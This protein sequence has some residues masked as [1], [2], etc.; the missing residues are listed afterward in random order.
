MAALQSHSGAGTIMALAVVSATV[1]A[2]TFGQIAAQQFYRQEQLQVVA[3]QIALSATDAVR[4]LIIGY[5]CELAGQLAAENMVK[6]AE[7]R[8]V[9]FEASISIQSNVMGIVLIANARAGPS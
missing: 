5:P 7:C 8:I 4:G 9:G 2:L 1:G 3:D 6:L